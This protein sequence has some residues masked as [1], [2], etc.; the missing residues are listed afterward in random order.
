VGATSVWSKLDDRTYV[1]DHYLT[2]PSKT[3]YSP[4]IPRC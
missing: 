4:P 1:S 2:T 3:T